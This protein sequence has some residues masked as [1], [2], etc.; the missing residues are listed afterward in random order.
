MR[1]RNAFVPLFLLG[2]VFLA[3]LIQRW[4]EPERKEAFDRKPPSLVY[5]KHALCRM[6]CRQIDRNEI[7]EVMKKG[8]I[9]FSKS[10]RM[11]RP[12]P[13][14]A[15]QGRTI[16]GEYLRVIFAQCPAETKV[17]TCYNL[18]QDFDCHCPGDENK[19]HR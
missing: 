5:T 19:N 4:N 16:S 15:L 14:F 18:E 8:I 9:N 3:F 10:D 17:I 12:C 6:D 11:D 7:Q 1:R 13:T 2:L